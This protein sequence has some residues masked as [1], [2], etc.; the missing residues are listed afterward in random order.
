M[1]LR[2]A[3]IA[4]QLLTRF[5]VRLKPPP[6]A[7]EIGLSLLWY[8]AIGLL[9][10]LLLWSAATLLLQLA[11]PLAAAI[12][13]VIWVTSTGALHLDGLADTADAW[14]GG[15]G[16]RD[17]TL[18]IMKDPYAGPVA[19]AAVFCVLLLKFGAISAVRDG[20]SARPWRDLHFA[21]A[22]ILPPLLARSSIPL[23]FIQTHYVRPGGIGAS[24]AQHQSR[25]GGQWII[26]LT[27]VLI[28]VIGRRHGLV[29]I[30][31][32]AAAYLLLRRTFIRRLGGVTGDCA[33]AM[34]EIIEV[35][36]LVAISCS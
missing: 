10:G 19:V 32:A 3:L 2:S 17:R 34:I 4:V 13:L 12:V 27:A 28:L 11:T 35:L 20:G 8:P 15:R 18:A 36:S 5:P 30:A 24:L 1:L 21:C 26:T 14:V 33:G 9:L 22:Y 16:D 31:V 7:R 25:A 23:L 29:A 6:V